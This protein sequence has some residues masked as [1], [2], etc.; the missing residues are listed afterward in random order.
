MVAR[1]TNQGLQSTSAVS[2]GRAY[3][4][5]IVVT[6]GPVE[7]PE[8]IISPIL[9]DSEKALIVKMGEAPPRSRNGTA[10]AFF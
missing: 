8:D 5:E 7:Q 3:V 9:V 6:R 4:K 1:L 2:A 10:S